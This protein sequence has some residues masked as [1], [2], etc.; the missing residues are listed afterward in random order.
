MLDINHPR[1][2]SALSQTINQQPLIYL[3]SAATTQKPQ[4][5]P[6]P[7]V[8]TTPSK[9]P[10]FTAVVMAAAQATSQFEAARDKVAQFIGAT[11]SKIVEFAVQPKHLT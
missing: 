8:N 9:M 4:V 7:L 2:V 1:A 5:L 6:I 11:S 10:M 3:D